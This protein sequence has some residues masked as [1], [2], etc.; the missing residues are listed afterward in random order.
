MSRPARHLPTLRRALLKWYRAAARAL[1]WRATRDPYR[2]WLSEVL[3]QQTRVET[4]LPYYLRL[5]TRFPNVAALAAAPFPELLRL[6]SGLGYYTRARHL[7]RAA[8]LIVQHHRGL[9]PRNADAWSKLPGIGPYTAGAIASIAFGECVPAVDGNVLRVLARLTF[10]EGALD[11]RLTR[12][13][14]T[15]H[16]A[17]LLDP[18]SPGCF[19]Q[20][21]MELGA[22]LCVPRRPKCTL[23]PLHR[24]CAARQAGAQDRLPVR[25]RRAAAPEIH[26][27]AGLVQRADCLLVI[28][29]PPAGALGDF[30]T[31]PAIA[32][33]NGQKAQNALRR[34][35]R[36]LVGAPV[37]VAAQLATVRH[38]F[39]HRRLRVHVF[40]CQTP[41]RGPSPLKTP[42][43]R[44]VTRN[45]LE[46]LP[47]AALDRK[48]FA[49]TRD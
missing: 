26:F 20:A 4:A 19:N 39:T 23:C 46:R 27:A 29:R 2:I 5:V 49:V 36:D 24:W 34:R 45:E 22:Q 25:R 42:D 30:W 31:L 9:L 14:L 44:W 40:A 43:V 7:H 35:L 32:L 41:G 1:P 12:Q 18:R 11:A 13:Q 16:A 8:R 6:W 47:H 10:E 38:D 3:L 21:L 48:L 33:T 28:R 37:R 15:R 17:E